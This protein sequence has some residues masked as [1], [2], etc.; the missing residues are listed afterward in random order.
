MTLQDATLEHSTHV[1]IDDGPS[2][3]VIVPVFNEEG[4]LNELTGRLRESLAP[5][6]FPYEILFVDDGSTDRSHAILERMA[7]E[8]PRIGVIRFRRNFGKAAALQCGFQ[9]ARG[10]IIVT[11]D[12]DLQDDPAEI[13][14][15][16]AKLGEGFD[17]VSGWKKERHDPLSK[18]IPSRVFNLVVSSVSGL[19][20]H[21]FNCG[22]KCYRR[23]ALQ[24]LNLYGELHR[25]LPV[26]VHWRGFRVA[27]IPVR[28]HPRKS[29]KSKFGANRL[30]T[31]FFDLLTV[32]L[33]T[34]YVARP[35]HLF[36]YAGLFCGT[37]GAAMLLYLFA[38]SIFGISEMRPRPLLYIGLMLVTVAVQLIATGLLAEVVTS[39]GNPS[40][41]LSILKD[42][43]PTSPM[44]SSYS[45][46]SG[47][48]STRGGAKIA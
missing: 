27:E 46:Q 38:L 10:E 36:G 11:L 24:G 23:E 15:L 28:H 29:G 20:L 9:R 40:A 14:R 17:L 26:L 18:T 47:T 6:D 44:T 8:D 19:R 31:G 25:Y 16:Y 32:M 12:A 7:A 3:S 13:R 33:T 37:L 21:D 43:S 48:P 45:E 41:D 42:T 35:L 1:A 22:L 34:R 4:S 2:L 30:L 5:L 39:R